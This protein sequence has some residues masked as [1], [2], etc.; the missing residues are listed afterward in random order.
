MLSW[1]GKS[2]KIGELTAT[3]P[4]IQGGTG[5]FA[6]RWLEI[7]KYAPA[8]IV[9]EGPMAGGHLGFKSDQIADTEYK[10]EK[11][12]PQVVSEAKTIED[13]VGKSSP[14]CIALALISAE[15]GR[16]KYGFDFAGE[17]A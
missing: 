16:M 8:A 6:K 9:V 12:V 7:Y 3:L 4:I 1:R 2:L 11:L 17:N 15:K 10:L 5:L 13:K 14:Y